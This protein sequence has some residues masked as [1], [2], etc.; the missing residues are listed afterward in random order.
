[1]GKISE[2]STAPSPSVPKVASSG[3]NLDAQG[4]DKDVTDNATDETAKTAEGASSS[5]SG[6][7]GGGSAFV[8]LTMM[9]KHSSV[10][11]HLVLIAQVFIYVRLFPILCL[12]G[13]CM[14]KRFLPH[15][16]KVFTTYILGCVYRSQQALSVGLDAE[17]G[18]DAQDRDSSKHGAGVDGE[19]V[20]DLSNAEEGGVAK[21]SLVDRGSEENDPLADAS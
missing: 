19:S 4:K 21:D 13:A 2:Y 5:G 14:Y 12:C 20:L 8:P 18:A 17:G 10:M 15:T 1:M 9:P 7:G 6:A 16:Y 3:A 11:G